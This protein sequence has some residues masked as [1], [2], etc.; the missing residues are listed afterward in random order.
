MDV[1]CEILFQRIVLITQPVKN[2]HKCADTR[3][4]MTRK[5]IRARFLDI[6]ITCR[7]S[8]LL[9]IPFMSELAQLVS[10]SQCTEPGKL[11]HQRNV[12]QR[13]KFTDCA[14]TCEGSLHIGQLT[15]FFE[16]VR[17]D[18]TAMVD[19]RDDERGSIRVY[20]PGGGVGV[21]LFLL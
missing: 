18:I 9:H 4:H 6:C 2:R 8:A 7:C 5:E 21:R 12:Q 14:C 11:R 20:R 17:P 1:I 13:L 15:Q 16:R 3:I 19:W 10:R